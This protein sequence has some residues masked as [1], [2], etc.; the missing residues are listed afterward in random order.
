VD[1]HS[2]LCSRSEE[3]RATS[4]RGRH[5]HSPHGP[6]LGVVHENRTGIDRLK[7]A[8]HDCRITDRHDLEPIRV[9]MGAGDPKY[10]GL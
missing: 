10:L 9:Q 7:R 3:G 8:A 6:T 4:A 1:F 5:Q 2:R